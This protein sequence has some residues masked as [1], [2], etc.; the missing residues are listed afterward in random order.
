MKKIKTDRVV[1][2]VSLRI[3]TGNHNSDYSF[4]HKSRKLKLYVELV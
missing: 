2:H 3:P 4:N 1:I